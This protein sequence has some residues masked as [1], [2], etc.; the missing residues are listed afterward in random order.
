MT[1]MLQTLGG[2]RAIFLLG[3]DAILIVLQTNIKP[4]MDGN[5]LKIKAFLISLLTKVALGGVK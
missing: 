3:L 1:L 4:L 5:L 2:T